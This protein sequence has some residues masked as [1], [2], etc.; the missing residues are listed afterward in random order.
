MADAIAG[1]FPAVIS[2][3]FSIGVN[4]FWQ[5]VR[6][7][8]RLLKDYDIEVIEGTSSEQ[9]RCTRAGLRKQSSIF[10]MKK[11]EPARNY[12]DGRA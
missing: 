5:M 4:I 9:K 8:A 10:L 6:E 3:N 7:A 2:S 1:H 11:S 12:M